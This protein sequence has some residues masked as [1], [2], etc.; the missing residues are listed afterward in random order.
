MARCLIG[1]LSRVDYAIRGASIFSL[2]RASTG[3]LDPCGSF[4]AYLHDVTSQKWLPANLEQGSQC[5]NCST[6]RAV[7]HSQYQSTKCSI[8]S[9]NNSWTIED[10]QCQKV[11]GGYAALKLRFLL[12]L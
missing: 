12:F 8:Q 11:G 3:R 1:V 9:C 10:E 6:H 4:L 7:M 2:T 5:Q